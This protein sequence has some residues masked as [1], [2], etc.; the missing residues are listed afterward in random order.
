MEFFATAAA[1]ATETELQRQ[2]TIGRLAEHCAS[3]D[4]VLRA[5]GDDGE[6]WSLWGQF[7]VHREPI[8]GGVR[9]TLPRC[10]NALAWTITAGTDTPAP[11]VVHCTIN[12]TE[13]DPDFIESIELFVDDWRTG[14]ER[15]A[16]AAAA[17]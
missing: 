7:Q 15:L 10:P 9:F 12:R 11:V 17:V 14:L 13:H 8:R 16:A 2:L 1:E 5:E 4:A 6:I 3:I